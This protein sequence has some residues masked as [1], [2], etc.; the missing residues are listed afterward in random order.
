MNR[1]IIK[2]V[3]GQELLDDI[4]KGLCPICKAKIKI[5]DFRDVLSL[6]EFKISRLCQNCQDRIFGK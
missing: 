5:E 3:F 2:F 1:E 4:D 6:K